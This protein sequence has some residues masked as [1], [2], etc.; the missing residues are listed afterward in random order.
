[1]ASSRTP[2]N[3][4]DP[5]L[6]GYPTSNPTTGFTPKDEGFAG[7]IFGQPTDGSPTLS[8]YCFDLFTDTW[9]GIGYALGTWDAATVPNVGYVARIL[10][11][12]YPFVPEPA[13]RTGQHHRAG[14]RRASGH[15][16]L[17]RSLRPQHVR[18]P[19]CHGGRDRGPHHL[20]RT[21]HGAAATEPGHHP[22]QRQ[23]G[24]H[25][26]DRRPV[27]G[28]LGRRVGHGDGDWRRHVFGRSRHRADRQL[29]HR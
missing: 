25:R 29:G 19:P 12:Y 16:V 26:R 2:P 20:G 13:R 4:F 6:D 14:G 11:E 24:Q 7:I 15:L 17:Q 22:D 10:N 5:V 9:P 1:M 23:R 3:P 28:D 27:H 8:L 21:G 18:S